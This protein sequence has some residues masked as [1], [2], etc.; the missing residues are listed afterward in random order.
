MVGVVV[1]GFISIFYD[2]FKYW[3]GKLDPDPNATPLVMAVAG[4]IAVVIGLALVKFYIKIP[5][6]KT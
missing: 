6:P 4:V 1:G 5:N 2:L 3:F